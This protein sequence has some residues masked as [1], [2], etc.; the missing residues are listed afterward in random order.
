MPG[1][2]ELAGID[3][4]IGALP[5]GPHG[6]ETVA[7]AGALNLQPDM[8]GLSAAL[9][10]VVQPDGVETVCLGHVGRLLPAVGESFYFRREGAGIGARLPA[11][12]AEIEVQQVLVA[13]KHFVAELLL[14][15]GVEPLVGDDGVLAAPPLA[16]EAAYC[17]AP[18]QVAPPLYDVGRVV[19][20]LGVQ[21]GLVR[22]LAEG[23]EVVVLVAQ[24]M[25][26]HLPEHPL[27]G[28]LVEG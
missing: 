10:Q 20:V 7:Q 18:A 13:Q 8:A 15:E 5:V 17:C 3:A 9:E 14:A 27:A 11:G 22:Q 19:D 16:V 25:G 23:F 12:V 4:A 2:A 28:H 21:V 1:Q 6:Y 24:P 26:V